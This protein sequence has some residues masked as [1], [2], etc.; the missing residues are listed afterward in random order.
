M[1]RRFLFKCGWVFFFTLLLSA[2]GNFLFPKAVTAQSVHT[3]KIIPAESNLW[4]YVAKAGLLSALAHNHNIGVKVF[5][6]SV[7]VPES[8]A[9]SGAMQLEIDAQSLFVADKEVNDKDRAEITSS[10][11]NEVLASAKFPKITFKSVSVSDVKP[12]GANSYTFT[13]NGDLTLHGIT[14]RIALPVN[15]TITPQLLKATGKYTLA[16]TAFG[17]TP[18]SKAGG[19]VKVKDE[20]VVNFSIVAKPV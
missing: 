10:M 4:V 18:I 11:H 7:T 14:K 9:G 20:V 8:G 15:A 12:A 5:N 1:D 13:V 16:Q 2:H 6:G 17:I 3:Y 19:A